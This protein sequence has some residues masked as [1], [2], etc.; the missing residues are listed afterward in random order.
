MAPR[1][2]LV[3][4]LLYVLSGRL[5]LGVG[6]HLGY[7]FTERPL[8]GVGDKDG[9]LVASPAPHASALLT[10]GSFGPDGSVFTA[11][12]GALFIAAIFGRRSRSPA[13]LGTTS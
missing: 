8:M 4:G 6:A 11:L 5:W 12:V 7:D 2:C 3:F 13:R 1:P 9:P 10:G